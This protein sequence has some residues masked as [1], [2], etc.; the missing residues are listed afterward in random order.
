MTHNEW[1]KQTLKTICENQVKEERRIYDLVRHD[2]RNTCDISA[3]V[4]DN[5]VALMDAIK[6]LMRYVPNIPVR[7]QREEDLACRI[8]AS[9]DEASLLRDFVDRYDA[10]AQGKESVDA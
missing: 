3:R 9:L 6:E 1:V 7:E 2:M 8:Q 10:E 5:Q 4:L